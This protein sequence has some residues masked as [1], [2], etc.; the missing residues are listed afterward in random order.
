MTKE[1]DRHPV[2]GAV[3][4][5]LLGVGYLLV[6]LPGALGSLSRHGWGW[7]AGPAAFGAWCDGLL[8]GFDLLVEL[9]LAGLVVFTVAMTLLCL[10]HGGPRLA[11]RSLVALV[12]SLVV[13]HVLSWIGTGVYYVVRFLASLVVDLASLIPH[14]WFTGVIFWVVVSAIGLVWLSA[15]WIGLRNDWRSTVANVAVGV[16]RGLLP[17]LFLLLAPVIRVIEHYVAIVAVALAV[18]VGI[19]TL[20]QLLV[21][22]V[23]SSLLAGRGELGMLMGAMGVGTALAALLV[24]SDEFGNYRLLPTP[25]AHWAQTWM[26]GAGPPTLDAMAALLVIALCVVGL[27]G[28]IAKMRTPPDFDEFRT[29]VI[30]SAVGIVA[31]GGLAAI[32]ASSRLRDIHNHS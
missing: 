25:V 3:L 18:L 14:G 32:S 17:V 13:I 27:A 19:A 24:E 15:L 4:A 10:R 9:T 16:V 1:R 22:Q 6:S 26:L 30:Y 23:R 7:L 20:G 28:N 29:S 12:L 5:F 31:A 21:D 8:P 2:A 11:R